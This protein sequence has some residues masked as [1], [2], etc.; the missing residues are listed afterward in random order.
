[1]N[2]PDQLW[3]LGDLY[4]F[5][6]STPELAIIEIKV[7]YESGPP[8]HSHR[9]EEETLFVLE[10]A[11]EVCVGTELSNAVPGNF[12][13]FPKGVLHTFRAT[14]PGGARILVT[15]S[16]G[17]FAQLFREIGVSRAEDAA[18]KHQMDAGK[19]K[20]MELSDMFG[21]YIPPPPSLQ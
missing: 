20:L 11:V 21:L 17:T 5:H 14:S 2:K 6:L 19:Q 18:D 10:G 12:I 7:G 13:H 8:L 9:S 1:M 15:I 3:V 4:T 16:P